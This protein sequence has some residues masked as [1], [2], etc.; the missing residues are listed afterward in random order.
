MIS[1]IKLIYKK[2][3][4]EFEEEINAVLADKSLENPSLGQISVGNDGNM[5]AVIHYMK[6]PL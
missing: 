4:Y 3:Y 5:L 1:Q 2:S 6:N